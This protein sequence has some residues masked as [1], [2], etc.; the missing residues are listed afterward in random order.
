MFLSR[1]RLGFFHMNMNRVVKIISPQNTLP[2]DS[3]AVSVFTYIIPITNSCLTIYDTVDSL[4][5]KKFRTT[6]GE[7]IQYPVVE[8]ISLRNVINIHND[9][10]IK[11]L[12]QIRSMVTKIQ[13]GEHI[14][15]PKNI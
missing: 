6:K 13:S 8:H 5:N 11:D 9:S 7:N 1:Y 2:S 14:L 15:S 3:P 10:G 4:E 12:L